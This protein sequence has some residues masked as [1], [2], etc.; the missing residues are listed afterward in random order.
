MIGMTATNALS[1]IFELTSYR[2]GQMKFIQFKEGILVK[3]EVRKVNANEHGLLVAF[4]PS[5]LYL[6]NNIQLPIEEFKDWLQKLCYT[7]DS[8]RIKFKVTVNYVGKEAA[9][10]TVYKKSDISGFLSK[11]APDANLLK[12]PII[13]NPNGQI[14]ETNIPIKTDEGINLVD[15]DRSLKMDV[16]INYNPDSEENVK[17]SF[18][19]DIETIEHGQ[20]MIAAMNAFMTF[21]RKKVKEGTKKDIEVL[22]NDI[23]FGLN[24][25]V[26]LKTDYSRGMFT[27]QTKHKMDN[28]VLYEPMRKMIA[29][30]LEEY[31]KYPENKKV[32]TRLVGVVNDNIKAR[33]AATK[34]RTKSAVKRK[35]F[36]ETQL[37]EGYTAPN[38]IDKNPDLPFEIYIIEG[39][40]AGGNARAGRYSN[41]IQGTLGLTGKPNQIYDMDD[42]DVPT[43]APELKRFFDD[44]LGCGFGKN[45]NIDNL[46]YKKIILGPDADVDGDHIAG[47]LVA[48][49]Y[50]HARPLIEQGYVYRVQA[51]LYRL[52]E[53]DLKKRD[54]DGNPIIDKSNYLFNKDAYFDRYEQNVS[55]KIALK[56]NVNDKFISKANMKRFLKT[57]RDY[58][59]WLDTMAKQDS[60][61]PDIIEYIA[62]NEDFRHTINDT[63][64][65]MYYDEKDETISGSYNMESYNIL[66]DNIFLSKIEYLRKIIRDGNDGIAFYHCYQKLKTKSEPEYLGYLTIGQIMARCQDSLKSISSRYKGLGEMD[67]NEMAALM[68]NPNNRILTKM[69]IGDAEETTKIMDELFMKSNRDVRKRMVNDADISLDDIDN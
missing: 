7:V 44:I 31:F 63:F 42:G 69:T 41:D 57:N 27:G 17:F 60:I 55:E 19:N 10:T 33:L 39:D 11:F 48:N 47:I 29:D 53:L 58:F 40:S 13:L 56:F 28:K 30:S 46:I 18:C 37:I 54:K 16:V 9:V 38:L 22:N 12:T 51:P 20:H 14:M 45:F 5:K 8:D 49:I 35:S 62:M 36:M 61:H 2:N 25:L 66:L 59:E 65:E 43:K 26:N 15:L 21:M 32:L 23:L 6:G 68:M 50:K 67:P 3:D 1:E 64:H 52:R 34:S 24:I 4:K